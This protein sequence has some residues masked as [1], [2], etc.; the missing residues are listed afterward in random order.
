ME[1]R[2]GRQIGKNTRSIW[3]VIPKS[4]EMVGET[5]ASWMQRINARINLLRNLRSFDDDP[6]IEGDLIV[7][8]TEEEL[9]TKI[10][11][12]GTCI[13]VHGKQ[14]DRSSIKD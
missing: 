10:D 9:N 2:P 11:N 4:I 1:R 3:P 8:G 5:L 13:R 12:A 7:H 6:Y 14:K